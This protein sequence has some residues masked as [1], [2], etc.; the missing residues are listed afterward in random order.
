M[1]NL[2]DDAFVSVI[3]GSES[4]TITLAYATYHLLQ[5]PEKVQQLRDELKTVPKTEQGTYLYAELSR[6]P[7]LV[8]LAIL[9]RISSSLDLTNSLIAMQ[10]AI[11]SESLRICSPVPGLLPRTVPAGGL[12]V[13][14]TLLP[15]GVCN[16]S[17]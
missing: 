5:Q 7:Y 2:V 17:L 4:T 3:A 11:V 12:Q 8:S 16:S 10:S 14:E 6:L 15:A 13:G 1:K 9:L